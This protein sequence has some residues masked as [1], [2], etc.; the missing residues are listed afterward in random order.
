MPTHQV[1]IVGA[2]PYGLAAASHLRSAGVE[3]TVFGQP[4]KFWQENMPRGMWLR[5]SWEASHISDPENALTLDK[6]AAEQDRK[7]PVPIPL[8]DFVAYGRW[9]QEQVVPDVDE[10]RVVQVERRE[11]GF[12]LVLDDGA[13][14]EADRVVIATGLESF[15]SRP[16]QFDHL[17]RSLALHSSEVSE[18]DR[19]KG[20]KVLVVGGGQ[21]AVESAVLL[22][23]AGADVEVV[24]RGELR[25]LKRSAWLHK[26][27]KPIR[28]IFY[29]PTDV[30]P[31]GLNW[32]VALPNV[33]KRMPS[34]WQPWIAYRSIRPAAAGWL[35]P[36]IGTVRITQGRTIQRA[37][38][39]GTG[40]EVALDDG[41]ERVVSHV[42]M[43]TGY[44]VDVR[45]Y[46]FL[47]A[48]TAHSLRSIEGYPDL[49]QGFESSVPGLH[50][51]GASAA[52]SFG[53]LM[54]FVAGT[55]YAARNLAVHVAR[56]AESRGR[57]RSNGN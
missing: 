36:R 56:G 23:E 1:V 17:S 52:I 37:R 35:A 9:F 44:R 39:A 46:S 28:R 33:F 53:P 6:Y 29:P 22:A 38:A 2:G 48:Q 25:W 5:S 51:I 30:G 54:R 31:P 20:K 34:S 43:A 21:S 19:F 3:T 4:M 12:R 42:L 27:P 32:I 55:G 11:R 49:R 41:S 47:S 57:V 24:L 45:C 13:S 26:Q 15:P 50:F 7:I 10:R 14:L 18:P 40:V 8:D 16:A